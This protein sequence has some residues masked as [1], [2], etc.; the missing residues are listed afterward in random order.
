[1]E[2]MRGAQIPGELTLTTGAASP[3]GAGPCTACEGCRHAGPANRAAT[4]ARPVPAGYPQ[5]VR[6]GLG[7]QASN[8]HRTVPRAPAWLTVTALETCG[9]DNQGPPRPPC[10]MTGRRSTGSAWYRVVCP[11]AAPVL[12]RLSQ[13]AGANST[14]GGLEGAHGGQPGRGWRRL[15]VSARRRASLSAWIPENVSRHRTWAQGAVTSGSGPQT[16][17]RR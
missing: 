12:Q 15:A 2:R 17:V 1:M 6:S 16:S 13:P 3:G 8:A 10:G 5:P 9:C 14:L 4:S 11:I 7:P